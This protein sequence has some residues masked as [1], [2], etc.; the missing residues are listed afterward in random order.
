M[1]QRLFRLF[2]LA[3]IPFVLVLGVISI[4]WLR[5]SNQVAN[6]ALTW[7]NSTP[8]TFGVQA[9]I[10]LTATLVVITSQFLAKFSISPVKV[11]LTEV[12][13]VTMKQD[14]NPPQLTGI[15]EID[16]TLQNLY[17]SAT[18]S[19]Q[20]LSAERTLAADVSHQLRSPLTALSL[21][22]EQIVVDTEA[23]QVQADANAALGQVDRLVRL[24]EGLLTTWRSTSDRELTDINIS[25]LLESVTSRWQSRLAAA[26]RTIEVISE[27]DLIALGT[28]E[29]QELVV[30]VLIENSL[31]HGAGTIRISARDYQSWIL[32]EVSDEGIGITADVE[33]SLMVQGNT[34]GGTGLGLAWAR[35]QVSI[36]G[37]RLELR[38]LKPATFGIFLMSANK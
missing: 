3:I 7:T 15:Q 36:D 23:T 30:S 25:E 27:P 2:A 13:N 29:I 32:I 21:R 28:P 31:Q 22:L 33:S 20:R 4:I 8:I 10:T 16:V 34:T 1:E 17:Q 12:N 6:L 11:L 19:Q 9:M 24:V 14:V 35:T 38:N 18:D 37:G 5:E 26:S